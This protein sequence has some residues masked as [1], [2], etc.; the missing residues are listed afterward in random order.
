MTQPTLINGWRI[1][2]CYDP[3][4]HPY[5]GRYHLWIAG[6]KFPYAGGG[7]DHCAKTLREYFEV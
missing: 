5:P 3:Q 7:L 1:V 4:G 2:R 6:F